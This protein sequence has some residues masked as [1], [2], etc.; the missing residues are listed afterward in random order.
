MY[1]KEGHAGINLTTEKIQLVEIVSKDNKFVA[2]NVD[3][4]YFSE[5][6]HL[7]EKETKLSSILQS[8][9]N[10]LVL[11]NPL[12]S[13]NISFTLPPDY[14]KIIELPYEKSLIKKD[15]EE[16]VRWEFEQLFPYLNSEDLV[17]QFIHL[18]RDGFSGDDK[19]LIAAVIK[20]HLKYIYKFCSR[21]NF[22][23]KYVDNAHFAANSILR[24]NKQLPADTNGLS[25][26]LRDNSFSIIVFQD[27][28]PSF[29]KEFHYERIDQIFRKIDDYL[30]N[31][32]DYGLIKEN[33]GYAVLSGD[34][35]SESVKQHLEENLSIKF[36]LLN[37]FEVLPLD[38]KLSDSDCVTSNYSTFTAAAGIALRQI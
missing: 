30:T 3:E 2:A 31:M 14:F 13:A 7:D 27:Y 5:S 28:H 6:V 34:R 22:N 21:N 23:L 20:K 24:L 37:P 32:N 11:R 10:E 29:Y 8:A 26:Y 1:L 36:S 33:I 15:L 19:I 35:S 25:L 38:E 18:K 12:A 17:I 9:F 4:E 16:H